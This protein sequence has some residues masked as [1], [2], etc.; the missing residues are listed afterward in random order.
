M[1]IESLD[2]FVIFLYLVLLLTLSAYLSRYQKNIKDYFIS[3]RNEKSISIA[4]S[5][6][7]TQCSTNSILGAPAFV[8]FT[9]GGGLNW[10]QYEL[11]VPL[12]M[13]AIMIFI[14]PTFYKLKLISIYEYLEKR[15]DSKTRLFLSG[16]FIL[17][18]VFATAVI[19]YSVSII[20]ELITGLDF[21][22][23]V[24]I[25]GLITVIYDILGGIKAIIYSDII[26]MFILTLILFGV[27]LFLINLL[28][29]FSSMLELLPENRNVNINLYNHGFGDGN[30]YAFWPMLIGGFFL[31]V[32][33]YGCDQS[34]MQR[35]LCAKNQKEGQ[36]IFFFNGI[37]RFPFVLLYCFIGVG[38]AAYSELNQN[39]I[40]SLPKIDGEPNFNLAVPVFL[41]ENLP[42]GIVGLTLVAL[43]AAAMSSLDSVL[44]S[45]SAVTMKDFI[46]KIDKL[47]NISEKKNIFLSRFITFFWGTV[48]ISLA[49][50]V[51]DISNN[52]LIAINK[53]GSLINGPILGVF[54]LGL[55]TKKINGSS[56]CTGLIF[57]FSA[58][59]YCWLY[60]DYI[61]WLWW[62][63][64]GFL[65]TIKIAFVFNII[66][67]KKKSPNYTWS[68]KLLFLEG[69]NSVWIRRYIYLLLWFFFILVILVLL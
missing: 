13:I 35:G 60:H 50:Y 45:L 63:V 47:N 41:I 57:G 7:A 61:S 62:N 39:F 2:W 46:S 54:T 23:A 48:A 22:F 20:I 6:L 9:A 8:A 64:I 68:K 34:Q 69:L 14:F 51:D 38:I 5:I 11:A 17:I 3:S 25:L 43:F 30:E 29:D 52:V 55:L 67:F 56:A 36:K 32:S 1:I 59:L 58:N 42:T 49:F 21:V 10:L 27:L 4:I 26:Q 28:G 33:Y 44:N 40:E 19:I 65:I 15:F 18:R 24:L 31:Y 37:L 53:I 66:F 12:S 16:L